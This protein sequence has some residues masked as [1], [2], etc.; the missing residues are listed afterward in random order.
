MG[1]TGPINGGLTTTPGAASIFAIRNGTY[2]FDT[3]QNQCDHQQHMERYQVNP[4]DLR[5]LQLVAD[6]SINMRGPING[7]AYVEIFIHGEP[8]TQADPNYGYQILADPN[9]IQMHGSNEFFYKIVFN[10][11]V[12]LVRPLIEV[13]YITRQ[14][15]CLK[16][17]GTGVLNDFA[18]SSSG[19]LLR[20]GGLLKLSQRVL[21]MVLTSR[22]AF[23]PQFTCPIKDYVG[24]KF[25]VTITDADIANA[26]VGSLNNLK[27]IQIAQNAFQTLSPEET[28]RDFTNIL[29]LQDPIDPTVV[30]VS[31]TVISFTSSNIGT[32]VSTPLEFSIQ[33]RS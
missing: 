17:N 12:R 14:P 20:I 11:E 6:P 7:I 23:Y 1:F 3:L 15:Y 29:A 9:R 4:N 2:D 25:G 16:C 22:C 13:N 18:Q 31:G 19:S 24:R 28:L 27:Q 30:H 5:T 32:L 33:V 8:I 21:K 10:G 26:V